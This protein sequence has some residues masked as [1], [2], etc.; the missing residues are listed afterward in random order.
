MYLFKKKIIYF[1]LF[2]LLCFT[3]QSAY[4]YVAD[5]YNGRVKYGTYNCLK[6]GKVC[7]F[8][9]FEGSAEMRGDGCPQFEKDMKYEDHK[10]IL[11]DF[12][13]SEYCKFTPTN[14]KKYNC[15][16]DIGSATIIMVDGKVK[17]ASHSD[18]VK[19]ANLQ[20]FYESDK[21]VEAPMEGDNGEP[22]LD[23]PQIKRSHKKNRNDDFVSFY[24]ENLPQQMKEMYINSLKSEVNTHDKE[25]KS[26]KNDIESLK[27][28]IKNLK[29]KNSLYEQY[30]QYMMVF[31][32]IIFVIALIALFKSNNNNP[33]NRL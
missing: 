25:I 18:R 2:S 7:Y 30:F 19:R 31:V 11:A 26:I 32:A 4:S 20:D 28:E 24:N 29:E 22:P 5:G 8:E 16:Y 1:L 10:K 14:A 33:Y 15:K 17:S 9:R 13:N 27:K 6:N 23:K 12:L 3:A 21:C